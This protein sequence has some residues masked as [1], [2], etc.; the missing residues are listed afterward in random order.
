MHGRPCTVI[1]RS[2]RLCHCFFLLPEKL[3]SIEWDPAPV[4]ESP[5]H[6]GVQVV[7]TKIRVIKVLVQG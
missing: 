4:G 2:A 5:W 7:E 3:Y 1:A 6:D